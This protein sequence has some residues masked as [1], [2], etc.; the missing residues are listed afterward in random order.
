MQEQMTLVLMDTPELEE[1]IEW[2]SLM[3]AVLRAQ[4]GYCVQDSITC[5]EAALYVQ[6]QWFGGLYHT[7][8]QHIEWILR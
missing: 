1:Q 2:K 3:A 4:Y 8:Q 5:A 7:P 6:L